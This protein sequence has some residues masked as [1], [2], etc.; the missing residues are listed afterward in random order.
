MSY[1]DNQ[2]NYLR[3]LAKDKELDMYPIKS[4]RKSIE[5]AADTID[6]LYCKY[7][8]VKSEEIKNIV[9]WGSEWQPPTKYPKDYEDILMYIQYT[10]EFK[11]TKRTGFRY[12]IGY[13]SNNQWQSI[14]YDLRKS[15]II[16]WIY[17]PKEPVEEELDI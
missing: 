12:E 4:I 6:M 2:I 7:K 16:A 10:S 14:I 15:K 9:H 3:D 11:D 5:S 17:L 1:I 8:I 13:R